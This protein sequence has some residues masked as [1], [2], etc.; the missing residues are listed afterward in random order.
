MDCQKNWFG[1]IS[2][3]FSVLISVLLMIS[4]FV[5]PS[6]ST[7]ANEDDLK[8]AETSVPDNVLLQN[9]SPAAYNEAV[10][11]GLDPYGNGKGQPFMMVENAE[12]FQF[13]CGNSDK[14]DDEKFKSANIY[15]TL[16]D[17]GAKH[18]PDGSES[19]KTLND[20]KKV[21]DAFKSS[22][23]AS[24]I[25]D[26]LGYSKAISF[27]PTGSGRKDH[28]ALCGYYNGDLYLY[29]YNSIT[30]M[31]SSGKKVGKLDWINEDTNYADV[32]VFT[33]ITAGDYNGDNID[34]IVLH[35]ASSSSDFGLYEFFVYDFGDTPVIDGS[36]VSRDVSHN[37][38][39]EAYTSNRSTLNDKKYHREHGKGILHCSLATGDIN[40]DDIDD[41]AV[42]SYTD[43]DKYYDKFDN[44]ISVP[45]LAVC[46]GNVGSLNFLKNSYDKTY[47]CE[48]NNSDNTIS[49]AGMSVG[50]VDGNGAD[51]IIIAGC[52]TSMN[53]KNGNWDGRT[54]DSNK[55]IMANYYWC[56]TN[57]NLFCS[58]YDKSNYGVCEY[59]KFGNF[60]D[61]QWSSLSVQCAYMNG[62]G[63][64]SYTEIDGT[65]YM[66]KETGEGH[67][68]PFSMFH[69]S[70]F[71]GDVGTCG[72]EVVEKSFITK[73]GTTAACF[74][75]N[76]KGYEQIIL[77]LARMQS[78][79][80][81]MY[82]STIIIGINY[83]KHT[84]GSETVEDISGA[85]YKT[86]DKSGFIIDNKDGSKDNCLSYVICSVDKN[87]D[88]VIAR[89]HKPDYVWSDPAVLCI[90]QAPPYF[91]EMFDMNL[92][93]TTSST[94][95]TISSTYSYS[96]DSNAIIAQG[97][98]GTFSCNGKHMDTDISAASFMN[99][100]N[101][102]T[103]TTCYTSSVKWV[104]GTKAAVCLYRVPWV[105][106]YYD[107]CN[108]DN[109]W[110]SDGAFISTQQ[111]PQIS[112][113][114]P[115]SYN[116]FAKSY[117]NTLPDK[118][119][120]P[121]HINY[122][123][124]KFI[125]DTPGN[126]YAYMNKEQ[127]VST[128]GKVLSETTFE[129]KPW[130]GEHQDSFTSDVNIAKTLTADI[131]FTFNL[132]K[133]WGNDKGNA[134]FEKNLQFMQETTLTNNKEFSEDFS[135]SVSNLK[136]DN[137]TTNHRFNWSFGT[138]PST[139]DVVVD[140][141]KKNSIKAVILGY[142]VSDIQPEKAAF[143][144]KSLIAKPINALVGTLGSQ[145]PI[146]QNGTQNSNSHNPLVTITPNSS[147]ANQVFYL[148]PDSATFE[149]KDEHYSS[150]ELSWDSDKY[151]AGAKYQLYCSTPNG[152]VIK[153]G[154][155]VS[156]TKFILNYYE[157]MQRYKDAFDEF[158]IE[159]L[160]FI[161]FSVA[162]L[163]ANNT[164]CGRTGWLYFDPSSDSDNGNSFLISKNNSRFVNRLN[165]K[166]AD[167]SG[168]NINKNYDRVLLK[169]NEEKKL[170]FDFFS[171]NFASESYVLDLNEN[172]ILQSIETLSIDQGDDLYRL[173]L[174]DKSGFS[175]N[176]VLRI[177]DGKNNFEAQ[178]EN[179]ILQKW[180]SPQEV[181]D[182]INDPNTNK[183]TINDIKVL[184]KDVYSNSNVVLLGD[185]ADVFNAAEDALNSP[186]NLHISISWSDYVS[187]ILLCACAL[188]AISAIIIA[189]IIR[190][191]RNKKFQNSHQADSEEDPDAK[192]K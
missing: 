139:L 92:Y 155:P 24:S 101:T 153:I 19:I 64:K 186:E 82:I 68:K 156:E 7:K 73:A 183:Q 30:D 111:S 145:E 56:S 60:G 29:V 191:Q 35:L 190:R 184:S 181:K 66:W 84:K 172:Y 135:V 28:V 152:E 67:S 58:Y 12:M 146:V 103:E 74:D 79:T 85:F 43:V 150:I 148:S 3:V 107:I 166:V 125:M 90:L 61:K 170:A 52:F 128:G 22:S 2:K 144:N 13:K 124:D 57:K 116:S 63:N 37:L 130:A 126:P 71:D 1:L 122:L 88:G 161:Q 97:F 158:S 147:S 163:N 75:G 48:S 53:Y 78:G 119:K 165:F 72:S 120:N 118:D 87:N 167:S 176:F 5:I 39:N 178:V 26:Y 86:S 174:Q 121:A 89:Y 10:K 32:D 17:T 50:N 69:D 149:V 177:P 47:V 134:D 27:D 127:L 98:S 173:E 179:E 54:Y 164:E 18:N 44:K 129:C 99:F 140:S 6:K 188:I 36:P 115:D 95:Y 171:R 4:V 40:G 113:D 49:I 109:T 65:I 20:T 104:A 137:S 106:Y 31:W 93:D 117:N 83:D 9:T 123:D 23:S 141:N 15:E 96:K 25:E 8:F 42:L 187:T 100:S 38:V 51:N 21:N 91:Q 55:L 110:I 157:L 131:G 180:S 151:I 34:T 59:S 182:A 132:S 94:E 133:S 46:Y 159:K 142:Q 33:E 112:C 81:D 62:W 80:K 77:S 162:T 143:S 102:F 138:W 160:P 175:Q 41:L 14:D 192:D 76:D 189:T 108:S 169:I 70:W 185:A 45:E 114:D 154:Q 16:K 136:V 11:T 168:Q 105:M